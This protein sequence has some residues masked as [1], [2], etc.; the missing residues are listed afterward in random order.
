MLLSLWQEEECIYQREVFIAG[1]A[2]R[3]KVRKDI[4][5]LCVAYI[6][7]PHLEIYWQESVLVRFKTKKQIL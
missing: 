7:V 2:L 6:T 3:L 4:S 5:G 1:D